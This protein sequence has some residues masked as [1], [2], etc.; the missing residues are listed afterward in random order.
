[1]VSTIFS[2]LTT[3]ETD[4]RIFYERER[5]KKKLVGVPHTDRCRNKRWNVKENEL[6]LLLVSL[7]VCEDV[8]SYTEGSSF[9]SPLKH[10]YSNQSAC[11]HLMFSLHKTH[12]HD[13]AEN[14]NRTNEDD[15]T[16]K[17][18]CIHF[19]FRASIAFY[20]LYYSRTKSIPLQQYITFKFLFCS[21]A[22]PSSMF[23]G[24]H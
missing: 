9:R 24:T 18:L 6:K 21:G 12:L 1:M 7:V 19:T 15:I 3:D 5:K 2:L 14:Q 8:S 11:L 10:S 4:V 22:V 20:R 17:Q 23:H 13:D 16:M